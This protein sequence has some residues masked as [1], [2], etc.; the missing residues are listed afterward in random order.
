MDEFRADLHTHSTCSDGSKTPQELLHLAKS[1]GLSGLS[2]TDHDSV[3]AYSSIP[4]LAKELGIQLISGVEF[5][6]LHRG[7]SIHI[8][9]YSFD[10]SHPLIHEFC[11]KHEQR[12]RNRN[13]AILKKLV[14]HGM[15]V[16]EEDV[17]QT[18][19]PDVLL[20]QRTIGRP[21]IALAMIKRGYVKTVQEAFK[22]FI[23][24][25]RPCYADGESFSTEESID[26]IHQAK[27]L[28]IIAHPHLVDDV[29]VLREMLEMKFDGMEC[30]YAKFPL[31]EQE[32]WIKKAQKKNWMITGGS[33]YHGD[34]K[35][36]IPL[37]CSYIGQ[38]TF[39]LLHQQ[40]L[41]NNPSFS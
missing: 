32:R 6:T 3:E 39:N 10:L 4:P 24:E 36:N 5:S 2:I 14:E 19:R 16:T 41:N 22:K 23:G 8:L 33:D 9:G 15:L 34:I 30:Y 20:T 12:R 21:H 40:F 13:R 35:P 25:G 31:A 27:G 17:E 1:I 18:C 29:S 28:A 26:I 38:E 7:C 11:L 37:G